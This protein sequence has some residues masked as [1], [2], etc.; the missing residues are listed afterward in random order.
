MNYWLFKSEP[1][2]YSFEDLINDKETPWEGIRNYQARNFIRDK[3]QVNDNILFYHSNIKTPHVVGIAKVS[4][5]AYPDYYAFDKSHKYYDPKS[6]KENPRWF[7]VDVQPIKKLNKIVT[8]EEIKNNTNLKD[9]L[10]SIRAHGWTRNLNKNN[11]LVKINQNSF[12][13]A[14]NFILPGYNVR[15]LEFSGA[16][17]LEQL[18][19]LS[20]FLKVRRANAKIFN[21]IIKNNTT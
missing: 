15:P 13:N 9:I 2:D 17:G 11:S 19:K 16:V 7:M 8:L 5:E 18:K 14:F 10:L 6:T 4:S 3:V 12:Q 1:S 21:D 20:T